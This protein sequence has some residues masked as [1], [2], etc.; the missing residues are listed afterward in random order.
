MGDKLSQLTSQENE[1]FKL[2]AKGLDNKAIASALMIKETT[3]NFHV[4]NTLKKLSLK[5]RLEAVMWALKYLS[6]NLE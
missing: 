2:L 6:D 3:V 1:T 4:T 5:N